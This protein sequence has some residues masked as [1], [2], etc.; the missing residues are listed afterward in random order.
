MHK[1]K[2][3]LLQRLRQLACLSQEELA[4]IV[5]MSQ[6]SLSRVEVGKRSLR[7]DELDRMADF[8]KVDPAVLEIR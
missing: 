4:Q 7:Q 2:T 5:D 6:S 8:F 1:T 3:P